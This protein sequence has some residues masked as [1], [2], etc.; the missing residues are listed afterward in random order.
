[1]AGPSWIPDT[2]A[3]VMLATAAYCVSRLVAARRWRRPTHDDVDGVHVL[4]GV[5]MAGM[6]V[7]RLNPF[8]DSG[9][10]VIFGV[11]VAWFGWQAIRGYRSSGT[12]RQLAAHHAQHLLA[13]GAMVY[14]FLAASA[15][16]AGSSA[17]GMS[18][19]GS[20]GTVARFPT[21]ALVFA[22]ALFGYVIWTTDRLTALARVAAPRTAAAPV[23]APASALAAGK[24]AEGMPAAATARASTDGAGSAAPAADDL[25]HGAGPPMSPRLAACCEIAMGVTMGYM[26][27]MML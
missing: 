19:A 5:A 3:V 15:V 8:W 16:R 18:M 25:P 2:L 12:R 6:L 21:L 24:V 26:L 4:M 9:W 20:S 14:M 22:L 1:V 23:A 17:P 13:S 10:E 7:P 27:I 11:A